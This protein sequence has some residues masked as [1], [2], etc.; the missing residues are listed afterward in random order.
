M[1]KNNTTACSE[2]L[3]EPP[4]TG[5][6]GRA[7]CR[8]CSLLHST[9]GLNAYTSKERELPIEEDVAS[10]WRLVYSVETLHIVEPQA[11]Q[12]GSL[13]ALPLQETLNSTHTCASLGGNRIQNKNYAN[14]YPLPQQ[15]TV[16]GSNPTEPSSSLL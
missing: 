1:S 15:E 10:V 12:K 5:P 7:A 9:T 4:K 6:A 8:A 2:Q 13:Q 16:E 11:H 3:A 14:K